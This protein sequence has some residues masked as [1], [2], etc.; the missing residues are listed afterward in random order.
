MVRVF[1]WDLN[2]NCLLTANIHIIYTSSDQQTKYFVDR[3]CAIKSKHSKEIIE[4][5]FTDYY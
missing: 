2:N 1:I 3:Y 4:N 5:S